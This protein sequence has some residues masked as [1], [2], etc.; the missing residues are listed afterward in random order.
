M[1][2]IETPE[3]LLYDIAVTTGEPGERMEKA[4]A[5]I[6]EYTKRVADEAYE[7]GYN[8]GYAADKHDSDWAKVEA[9]L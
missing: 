1:S 8:N 4:M 6:A 2:E 9:N 3:D 5:I 7:R